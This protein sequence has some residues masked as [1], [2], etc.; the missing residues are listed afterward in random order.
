MK[1]TTITI[2][3][4]SVV[5]DTRGNLAFIQEDVL[6]FVKLYYLSMYQV[7]HTEEGIHTLHSKKH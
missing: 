7:M 1:T 5:E 3:K 6:P 2:I 4:I